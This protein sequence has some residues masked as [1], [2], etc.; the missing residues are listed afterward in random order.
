MWS[1]IPLHHH[2]LEA[3][4]V[5]DHTASHFLYIQDSNGLREGCPVRPCLLPPL[6]P[7]QYLG[8]QGSKKQGKN[9]TKDDCSEYVKTALKVFSLISRVL[10]LC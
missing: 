1:H 7:A 2:L 4:Y 9:R 8:A 5:G 10:S 3:G 6:G